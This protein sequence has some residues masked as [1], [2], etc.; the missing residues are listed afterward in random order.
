MKRGGWLMETQ[1][2]ARVL[3]KDSV[4]F[5]VANENSSWKRFFYQQRPLHF[6]KPDYVAVLTKAEA[7]IHLKQQNTMYHGAPPDNGTERCTFSYLFPSRKPHNILYNPSEGEITL[8]LRWMSHEFPHHL[9]PAPCWTLCCFR[10][11]WGWSKEHWALSKRPRSTANIWGWKPGQKS[12][13]GLWW[14][15]LEFGAG[16]AM[17]SAHAQ[18]ES[19]TISVLFKTSFTMRVQNTDAHVLSLI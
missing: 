5:P 6:L 9:S 11:C 16:C 12:D 17:G 10:V 2:K 7:I 4:R 3:G 19:W 14:G 15:G 1:K 8:P 13:Y 18:Q